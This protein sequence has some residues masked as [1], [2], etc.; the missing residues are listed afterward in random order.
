MG[1]VERLDP[2]HSV[3]RMFYVGP[4]A[5][6]RRALP[7]LFPIAN[8]VC[9][10]VVVGTELRVTLPGPGGSAD[11]RRSLGVLEQVLSLLGELEDAA[12]NKPARQATER[13]TWGVSDVRLGSIIMTFA[14]NTPKRGATTRVLADVLTHAVDGFA[15]TEEREGLPAGWDLRAA[16]TAAGLTQ[17]LGL[18]AS[19]GMMVELLNDH[20]VQRSVTV[21]R[22]SAENLN[23][24]LRVRRESIGSV[25]GTLESVSVRNRRRE[26]GLWDE[27]TGQRVAL[28]FDA[29]QLADVKAAIG[30]RVEV[31]GRIVRDVE[32]RVLS[33]N[34]RSLEVLPGTSESPA[35]G[36][37]GLSPD[38]IGDRTPE[39]HLKELR[40]AS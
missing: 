1:W 32:D 27:V 7:E 26:A 30:L 20:Q 6:H 38:M 9:K 15:V 22:R 4:E 34:M 14:P 8:V 25:V 39:E 33:L 11:A 29:V 21:T 16:A 40:G 28:S 19:T 31:S 17:A 10:G 13:T 12:L 36:L 23:A 35:T 3:V 2:A 18:M 5:H 24:T 37:V